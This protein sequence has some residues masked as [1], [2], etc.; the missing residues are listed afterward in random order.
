M[1][2]STRMKNI[3][4]GCISASLLMLI[5]CGVEGNDPLMEIGEGGGRVT[6]ALGDPIVH[7]EDERYK[8][9]AI[10][11]EMETY[12]VGG[13]CR[14]GY[15]RATTDDGEPEVRN[16]EVR[17]LWSG[18]CGFMGWR[19]PYNST[20]CRGQFFI[21][22]PAGGNPARC[23]VIIYEERSEATCGRDGKY[24]G[25]PGSDGTCHCDNQCQ[26]Y[27]DCCDDYLAQCR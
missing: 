27:G 13:E 25:G 8:G 3:V 15:R 10:F 9:G 16:P 11:E 20:D 26:R 12:W 19:N 5:G 17:S 22:T 7:A 24:C 2:R 23:A 18:W 6:Q 4:G 1:K 14:P 21:K